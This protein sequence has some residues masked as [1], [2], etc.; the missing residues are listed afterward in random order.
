MKLYVKKKGSDEIVNSVKVDDMTPRQI[1]QTIIR[2]ARKLDH[3]KFYID[4]SE[5]FC[6]LPW[7]RLQKISE[8]N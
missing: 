6:K 3:A 5:C 2:V 1:E 8:K 4:D 7:Q